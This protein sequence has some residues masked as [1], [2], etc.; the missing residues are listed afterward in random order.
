MLG[1]QRQPLA[2]GEGRH[3]I[4]FR[5]PIGETNLDAI[6]SGIFDATDEL[7]SGIGLAAPTRT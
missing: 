2:L 7:L 5:G 6:V 3:F 1:D 4:S